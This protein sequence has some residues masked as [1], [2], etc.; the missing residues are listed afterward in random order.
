MKM[1]KRILSM[2]L[3]LAMLVTAVPLTAVAEQTPTATPETALTVQGESSVGR[4]IASALEE[5]VED[6]EKIVDKI[7]GIEMNGNFA[8]IELYT[9][10]PATVVVGIFDEDGKQMLAAGEAPVEADAEYVT[11]E[12]EGEMPAYYVARAFL[13]DAETKKPLSASFETLMYTQAMQE[14][15]AMTVDDFEDETVLNLDEDKTNNFA[16]FADGVIQLRASGAKDVLV[17]ADD[18]QH[19]YVFSGVTEAITGLGA[20][21]IV[22]YAVAEDDY[23]IFKVKSVAVN[24]TLAT[25]TGDEELDIEEVFDVVKINTTGDGEG[26]TVDMSDADEGVAFEGFAEEKPAQGSALEPSKISD[27]IG[28]SYHFS[29]SREFNTPHDV[30]NITVSGDIVLSTKFTFQLYLLWL[31]IEI[32]VDYSVNASGSFNI[33]GKLDMVDQKLA[34]LFIPIG[35]GDVTVGAEL[36]LVFRSE[37][38]ITFEISVFQSNGFSYNSKN[39]KWI[40][41]SIPATTDSDIR[42]EVSFFFGLELSPK[43]SALV[44]TVSIKVPLQIGIEVSANTRNRQDTVEERH[45]CTICVEGEISILTKASVAIEFEFRILFS[46]WKAGHEATLIEVKRKL[47]DFYWSKELGFGWGKCPNDT[48]R[49]IFCVIDENGDPVTDAKVDGK[50]TDENGKI[51]TYYTAGEKALTVSRPGKVDVVKNVTVSKPEMKILQ[52]SDEDT[53][54]VLS[55]TSPHT[56]IASGKCDDNIS[57]TLLGDGTLVITGKGEIPDFACRYNNVIFYTAAPWGTY[58]DSIRHVVIGNGIT[59][60]GKNAFSGCVDLI[61]IHTPESVITI[62]DGAFSDCSSL[63]S[64]KIPDGVTAIGNWGLQTCTSLTDVVIGRGITSIGEGAFS[65]CYSLKNVTIPDTVT[66]IEDDAF[67]R[68]KSLRSVQIPKSVTKIGMGAFYYCESLESVIIPDSV[69]TLGAWAFDTCTGLISITIGNGITSIGYMTFNDCTSLRSIVIGSGIKNVDG[70]AFYG[71][72]S[73][74]H[75]N[76]SDL[77]AWCKIVFRDSYSNPLLYAH[78]LYINGDLATEI[79]I[80][81]SVTSIADGAFENCT[82]LTSVTIKNGISSIGSRTFAGCSNLICVSI[83]SSVSNIGIS[84]F[85]GCK[86]LHKVEIVDLSA[87]CRIIFSDSNSN[88]LSY[89]HD[90]YINGMLATDITIPDTV[91][92]IGYC[93]FYNCTSLV[94]VTFGSGVTH[95][96]NYAFDCCTNLDTITIADNIVSIGEGAFWGCSGLKC[97]TIGSCVADIGGATFYDCTSL[98]DIYYGGTEAQWEAIGGKNARYPSTTTVHYNTNS[99]SSV[100]RSATRVSAARILPPVRETALTEQTVTQYD[101]VPGAEYL[102]AVF[103]NAYSE[104]SFADASLLYIAQAPADENGEITFTYYLPSVPAEGVT[105]LILGACNHAE[106]APTTILEPTDHDHGLCACYCAKCGELMWQKETPHLYI[107][108][109]VNGDQK[110][111]ADDLTVIA[112]F[113]AKITVFDIDAL[114]A[115]DVNTDG[116]VDSDDLTQMAKYIA[117][118]ISSFD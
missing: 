37:G 32:D 72:G 92:S 48:C 75:V 16:V 27:S 106:S 109:D 25:V 19:L 108:G 67:D 6:A 90:L 34:D 15:L 78:A 89:A 117:K 56:V 61:D 52:L 100:S 46:K 60:I 73:L 33:S 20:G 31:G 114:A 47:K 12:I 70:Y 24:G 63:R 18:E 30:A 44:Q 55:P 51:T 64:L 62:G 97:A 84:A 98:T 101:L 7:R 66:S 87:W 79:M 42:S 116:R 50:T 8:E 45:A 77:A 69:T 82:S 36:C 2:I 3:A 103:S 76:I 38:K 83:P 41:T 94:S 105:T 28:H 86:N 110:I 54:A 99:A 68:C 59:G 49:I 22:C 17:S 58:I 95:I 107:L 26:M 43:I 11:V 21:D 40:D 96:G 113:V 111:D 80:P 65:K 10:V 39:G 57:Y 35:V 85:V 112:K 115:A 53:P 88:P 81:N 93:A 102:L 9:T 91:T 23:V 118:I 14:L 29:L 104:F 5:E 71:C 4:L 74:S 13:L 1:K